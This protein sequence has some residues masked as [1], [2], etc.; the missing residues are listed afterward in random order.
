MRYLS[1][2]LALLPFTVSAQTRFFYIPT[3]D[4]VLTYPPSTFVS[5]DCFHMD[6]DS[7]SL[8][9]GSLN[10]ARL[11]KD[12]GLTIPERTGARLTLWVEWDNYL[13]LTYTTQTAKTLETVAITWR[14][15]CTDNRLKIVSTKK[16]TY[17]K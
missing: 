12:Y 11:T 2:L 17:K 7:M 5:C 14:Y 9:S 4:T 16:H 10:I 1:F 15:D 13:R 3:C 6:P 8:P